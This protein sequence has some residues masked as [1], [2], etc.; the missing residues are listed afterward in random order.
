MAFLGCFC[1]VVGHVN[2]NH[3]S[4]LRSIQIPHLYKNAPIY[5]EM[6]EDHL[7]RI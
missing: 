5:V 4:Y 2:V 1:R 7:P 6:G 3:L